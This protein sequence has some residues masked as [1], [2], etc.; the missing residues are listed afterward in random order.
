MTSELRW[1]G[2]LHELRLDLA[3]RI[4]QRGRGIYQGWGVEFFGFLVAGWAILT[5]GRISQS[6][7]LL[8]GAALE[9]GRFSPRIESLAR[10]FAADTD[11]PLLT[12]TGEH[13]VYGW[14]PL[15]QFWVC[16]AGYFWACVT[17]TF[18]RQ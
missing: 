2:A 13:S 10:W 5:S 1:G 17:L 16:S 15:P 18:D 12:P 4:W 8:A 9:C 3:E 11:C 14:V 6:R 7:R